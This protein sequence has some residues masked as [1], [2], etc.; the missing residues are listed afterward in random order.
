VPRPELA[1]VIPIDDLRRRETD[2]L[3]EHA[4]DDANVGD[5][6]IAR[7]LAAVPTWPGC[8]CDRLREC[9]EAAQA[10]AWA[11]MAC[12]DACLARR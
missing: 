1:R 2:P 7:M 3:H 12:A 5:N 8:D 10:V 4:T 6:V 9:I 11:A